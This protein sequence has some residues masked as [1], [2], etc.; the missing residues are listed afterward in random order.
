[1]GEAHVMG[2]V[3]PVNGEVQFRRQ[4]IHHRHT[5]AMQ[6][7]GD[8]VGVLV[9]LAAGV[10][11]GHDDFRSRALG[12]IVV[13]IFDAGRDA[14]AI[15]GDSDG[16]FGIEGD[17]DQC[18][19]SCERFVNGIVDHFIDHVMQARAIIGVPDIHARTFSDGIKPLQDANRIRAIFLGRGHIICHIQFHQI[20]ERLGTCHDSRNVP[21]ST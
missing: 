6:A 11:L 3:V 21:F 16:A 13:V 5:H 1:M 14:A 7:A 12:V 4:G 9:K 10:Q 18:G 19:M 20:F 15:V 8:L 17:G 2:F